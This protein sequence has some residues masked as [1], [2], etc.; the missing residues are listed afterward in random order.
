MGSFCPGLPLVLHCKYNTVDQILKTY[1]GAFWISVVCNSITI[2]RC[3]CWELD[4]TKFK[5]RCIHI[6]L[7]AHCCEFPCFVL[8]DR[9]QRLD[10]KLSL[11][12]FQA[13]TPLR[14]C[15]WSQITFFLLRC[16]VYNLLAAFSSLSDAQLLEFVVA[17]K[18]NSATETRPSAST[19]SHS[20]RKPCPSFHLEFAF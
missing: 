10:S 13:C 2:R 18:C 1:T 12:R 14:S 7:K 8:W 16:F 4:Y 6:K 5:S 17:C 9:V 15:C 20:G 19:D 3:L 11:T